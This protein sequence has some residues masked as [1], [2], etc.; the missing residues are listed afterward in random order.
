MPNQNVNKVVVNNQT[1]I[2]LTGDT[3]TAADVAQGK[4]FH[5]ASGALQTGTS[6]GGG[7]EPWSGWFNVTVDGTSMYAGTSEWKYCDQN[8]NSIR[9]TAYRGI[10]TIPELTKVITYR[11][12][13]GYLSAISSNPLNAFATSST[14]GS[15]TQYATIFIKEDCTLTIIGSCLLPDTLITLADDTRK[16]IKDI[17]YSDRLK[18][19]D[20]DKGEFSSA[21][22]CWLT[23]SGLTNDH[24]YR[25]TFSDGTVVDFTGHK[26]NHKIYNVDTRKFE[27]VNVTEVGDRIFSEN[28]IVT[29][30]K[31]EYIE[32]EVE[33]YNLITAG[34]I[35]CF[36]GG[37]LAADRY[38]NM[39]PIDEEMRYVKNDRETRPYSEFEPHRIKKYWYDN[40]RL[41]ELTEDINDTVNYIG[42]L[43]C[44]MLDLE[45]TKD[46]EDDK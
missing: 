34:K 36:C 33:Y 24:L 41:G 4:T 13:I 30:T 37:I 1:I 14:V 22:I 12:P 42:K 46:T 11:F 15:T 2:D 5:D 16:P 21:P 44:Q 19:W 35:N 20:F 28:G 8:L 45:R 23:R 25:L 26:S 29:V 39:Y 10:Y 3:A 18:V 17:T 31:K 27:G 9:F 43:E 40:L 7:G 32:K 38:G 6:S